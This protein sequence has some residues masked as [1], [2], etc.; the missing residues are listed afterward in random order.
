MAALIGIGLALA[1]GLFAA[2]LGFDRDRV[3]YPTVLI[4]VASYYVPF[5][6]MAGGVENLPA[7]VAVFAAFVLAAV[8]GFRTN[9][10]VV[11]GALAAHATYDLC[12]E[13]LVNRSGAPDWWPMF[14]LSYDLTAAAWL[15]WRLTRGTGSARAGQ[16][17]GS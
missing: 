11:V 10:W 14:C 4:V 13:L 15:A 7:E 3:F 8:V 16:A 6:A 9:L 12:H 5:A 1:V 2:G 17:F